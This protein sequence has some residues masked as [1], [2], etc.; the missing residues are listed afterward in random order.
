MVLLSACSKPPFKS[1]WIKEQAPANFTVRFQTTKGDFDVAVTRE[2]SP[3]AAD[4]LL[5]G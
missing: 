2:W 4:Q 5:C 1:K 3:L